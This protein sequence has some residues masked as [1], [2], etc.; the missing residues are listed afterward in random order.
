MLVVEVVVIG[1]SASL[2]S[3]LQALWY[4]LFGDAFYECSSYD[5]SLVAHFSHGYLA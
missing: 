2:P 5:A 3:D 4:H 1:I